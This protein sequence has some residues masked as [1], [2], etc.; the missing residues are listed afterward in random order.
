MLPLFLIVFWNIVK[1][2]MFILLSVACVLYFVAGDS[3]EG[4]L[5]LAAMLFV[6]AIS[7]YQEVKSAKAIEALQQYTEPKV[8]VIRDGAE[9]NIASAELVPGDI[10]QLEEGNRIPA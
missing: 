4:M 9:K 1:E 2:P 8:I 5:M 3:N 7:V 10:I 6:T